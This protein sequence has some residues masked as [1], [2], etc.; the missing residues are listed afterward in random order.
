VG[1]LKKKTLTAISYLYTIL[2]FG[3]FFIWGYLV[4]RE[5]GVIDPA[6]HG[7][8]L[9]LFIG[10]MFIALVFAGIDFYSVKEK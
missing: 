6:K 2:V 3:S 4:Q 8:P 9:I 1:E 10:F 7:G 5:E